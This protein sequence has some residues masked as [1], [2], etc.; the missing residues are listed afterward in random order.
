MAIKIGDYILHA[1]A[2][3]KIWINRLDGEGGQF[4]VAQVEEA[5]NI[6]WV[7]YF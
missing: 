4:D 7:K 3:G 1:P 5:L 6:L 2:D